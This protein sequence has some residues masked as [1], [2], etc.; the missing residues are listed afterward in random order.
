LVITLFLHLF[1]HILLPLIF[2]MACNLYYRRKL[3]DMTTLPQKT[4]QDK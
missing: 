3:F 2:T 1:I 4:Q